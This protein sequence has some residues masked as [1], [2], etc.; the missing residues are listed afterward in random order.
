MDHEDIDRS[1]LG[2]GEYANY[3]EVGHDFVAFYLD[4]GQV[5]VADQRTKVYNR[6]ITS[7]IGAKRLVNVLWKALNEYSRRFGDIRDEEGE[8][9]AT[10]EF[11]HSNQ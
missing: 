5:G 9:L 1:S 7:P 3:F 11:K 8:V 10:D 4:C 2:K 6:I